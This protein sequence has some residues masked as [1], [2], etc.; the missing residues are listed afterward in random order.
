MVSQTPRPVCGGFEETLG[1]P[2]LPVTSSRPPH[3]Y[4]FY[5]AEWVVHSW[6]PR[7]PVPTEY[8]NSPQVVLSR[9][10]LGLLPSKILTRR[11]VDVLTGYRGR[12]ESGP[13]K[14]EIPDRGRGVGGVGVLQD[15]G[16]ECGSTTVTSGRSR[17][18]GPPY[19]SAAVSSEPG[20]RTTP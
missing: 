16:D 18:P 17:S 6:V 11:G 14:G 1:F 12:R 15:P 20:H 8:T 2:T 10:G 19:T 3:P 7:H 13:S 9:L 4:R 5:R